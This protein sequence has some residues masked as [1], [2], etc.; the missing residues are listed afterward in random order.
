[1][2]RRMARLSSC[3]KLCKEKNLKIENCVKII[4]LQI[5]HRVTFYNTICNNLSLYILSF[6]LFPLIHPVHFI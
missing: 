6:L 3:V 5:F 2:A 4:I 1:M